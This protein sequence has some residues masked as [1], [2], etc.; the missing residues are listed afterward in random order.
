MKKRVELWLWFIH[1]DVT[2]RLR[3]SR[4]RMSMED[5]EAAYPGAWRV[6]GS[7]EI[8]E[9]ELTRDAELGQALDCWVR[10]GLASIQA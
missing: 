8:A 5:A 4:H 6:P 9:I 3:V 7:M 1:D 10:G 2:D